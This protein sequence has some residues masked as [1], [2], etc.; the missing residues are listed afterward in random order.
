MCAL[1]AV[2]TT[3]SAAGAGGTAADRPA[4][5]VAGP[6]RAASGTPAALPPRPAAAAGHG[7]VFVELTGGSAA[8]A[9]TERAR[10][11]GDAD[12]AR[13]AAVEARRAVTGRAGSVADA[14]READ[15]TTKVLAVTGNAVPGLLVETGADGLRALADRPDVRSIRPVTAQEKSSTHS[16]RLT[17]ALNA[18]QRTGGTG[19]GVRVGIVDDGIDYT[20]AAFGGPGTKAAYRAVDPD[21]VAPG[22]FPTPKVVGGTDFVGD[23]YDASGR[24]GS[25]TPVPDPNPISCGHH[26]TH[27][28]S[29]IAS[30]GVNADGTT[31]TGDYAG[32]TAEAVGAMRVGPGMAPE[33]S[34]YALKVFGCNGLTS[35]LT[36][37]ALDHALDPDGDGDFSDRLDI[38]SLALSSNYNSVDDPLSLFVRELAR[39]DVLAV[40]SAGNGGD[41]Y[42]VAGSPGSLAPEALTVG[43]TRDSY[44]L[45]DRARVEQPAALAGQRLGQFSLAYTGMDTLDLSREV[46][47]LPEGNA[48]GC[49]AYSPGE[50]AA[51]AGR[52]VWLEMHVQ[53][54]I[55]G[56]ECGSVARATHAQ[57]A[58][59]AAVVLSSEQDHFTSRVTGT[60]GMPM[61]Q[62]TAGAA[63]AL[64]PA[65]EAGTLRVRLVGSDRASVD[66]Y[67]ER[68]TDTASEFTS[69]GIRGPVVKPDLS[70][71]GDTIAAAFSGSGTDRAVYSGTSMSAPHATG[72]MALIRQAHPEWTYEEAKAAAMN[73]A[74]HDI[75]AD[76]GTPLTPQ[77]VGAG[78]IDALAALRTRTLAYVT[79]DPGAV[80]ASFGV[81]EVERR[82][83]RA[84]TVRVVN[85][86]G[87]E[88]VFDASYRAVAT[89]PGVR[90]TVS[91]SRVRVPA[92]GT[93]KVTV[94][95]RI[96]DA[97]LLRKA[98]EPAMEAVQGGLARQFVGDTSGRLLLT[99]RAG[100]DQTLRVPVAASPK[101]VSAVRVP[102][103]V[104]PRG[105]DA[106]ALLRL[107][108][109]GL[110]QGGGPSAYRGLVSAFELGARSPRLPD[111]ADAAGERCVLNATGRGG[112]LRYV[113]ATSTAPQARAAGRPQDALAAFAVATWGDWANIGSNTVPY[114]RID[115]TGDGT[116]DF[117]S[118]VV[119]APRSDVLLVNTV[120]L[121]RPRPGGGF[122]TVD[123]Q[124]VNGHHGDVDT[125]TF[126]TNVVVLPVRLAALGVDPAAASH[127]IGYTVAVGGFYR[128]PGSAV[129]DQL[130]APV[131]YDPLAPRYRVEAAGAPALTH[132]ARPGTA[133]TV[134]AAPHARGGE[135]LAVL[136]HNGAGHRA[137][138]VTVRAARR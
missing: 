110:D 133:L 129:V 136:H 17:G 83:H 38:V 58:G 88:Q 91:P 85:K 108:G 64:R 65:L 82:L 28:A 11:G 75:T 101:P 71:P 67:D 74:G 15:R 79:E 47:R 21:T 105:A 117:E 109:R 89:M 23:D 119:K 37:K 106:R 49:T 127:P 72:I 104:T 122:T 97:R 54:T 98:M 7:T 60:P 35:A 13:R 138:V 118:Y 80:S 99:P 100:A 33:A 19:K 102:H 43:S 125:N 114:V 69:R 90:F 112:D 55:E 126:D 6:A 95:L 39:H 14:L 48:R 73:T 32:L 120:D 92:H 2:A 5:A 4:P 66:T 86:S 50:A 18:W 53:R 41:L 130:D 20:H 76:D 81:V 137:D 77:R 87:R 10:G 132:L 29:I 103:A 135:L 70:A 116:P 30:Q 16:V 25:T 31:F 68:L 121:R 124:P 134:H 61:F 123:T 131:A 22:T 51:V 8:D 36:A 27:G 59:A 56:L 63:K 115:T 3:T 40:F 1:A 12:A 128:A 62:F 26:G 9:A 34:L 42:D 96:D 44:V 52:T 24:L 45:R 78:R 57:A 111:C 93:A 113:G 94:T 107:T 46:V 84:K